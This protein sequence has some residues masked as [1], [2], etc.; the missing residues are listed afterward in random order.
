MRRSLVKKLEE[1]LGVSAAAAAPVMMA[2]GGAAAGCGSGGRED[3]VHR[4]PQGRRREQD[5][6]H[7]G[8]PRSHQP[9]PER[10]QG[11]GRWRAQDGE[12]RRLQGRSGDHQEEVH[13]GRRNR[14]SEVAALARF[15]NL[16]LQFSGRATSQAS[17][18][19]SFFSYVRNGPLWQVP[20][21]GWLYAPAISIINRLN[22]LQASCR[23]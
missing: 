6:R 22:D 19:C 17:H 3:G 18:C 10:S 23:F 11:P 7:Q 20:S 4:H 16:P 5:Q 1:R 9:G 15:G 12:G 14:R 13:R 21:G 2:G 8:G